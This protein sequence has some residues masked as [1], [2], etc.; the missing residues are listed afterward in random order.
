M[1]IRP[2]TSSEMDQTSKKQK[3]KKTKKNKKKKKNF[4]CSKARFSEIILLT[5]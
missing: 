2:P 5:R 4:F 3:T 1:Q